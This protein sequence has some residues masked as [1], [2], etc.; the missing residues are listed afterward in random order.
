MS[1][2]GDTRNRQATKLNITNM[3]KLLILDFLI[4][5]K[6][7]YGNELSSRIEETFSGSYR[8]SNGLIYPLLRD[9]EENLWIEGWWDE[10][11]K[12]SKRRYKITDEGIKYF[13]NIKL[14]YKPLIE[15]SFAVTYGVLNKIYNSK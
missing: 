5:D 10:P 3:L 15:E 2:L 12:K 9:M 14:I 4:K 6:A 7:C 13:N 8:P 1:N 11:D